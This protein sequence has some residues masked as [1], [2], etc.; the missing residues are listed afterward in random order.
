[1]IPKIIHQFWDGSP[2]PEEFLGYTEKWGE[3]HPGWE[4]HF[5]ALGGILDLPLQNRQLIVHA[6]TISPKSPWPFIT[7]VARYELLWEFGGVWIDTDFDPQKPIDELCEGQEAWACWEVPGKWVNNAILAAAPHHPLMKDLITNLPEHLVGMAPEASN[8]CKSG[9]QY[10]TPFAIRHRLHVYPSHYFFPYGWRE[11]HRAN[12]SFPE[13]YA[14]H[15]WNHQRSLRN[16]N[17]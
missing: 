3:L 15:R 6:S 13:S 1:M 7:D 8:T 11:L 4:L 5:W 9:P 14:V 12:E 10:L 16:E 17:P 2:C